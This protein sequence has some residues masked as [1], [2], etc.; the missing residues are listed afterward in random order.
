MEGMRMSVL[1]R[2]LDCIPDFWNHNF[3]CIVSPPLIFEGAC[4][5]LILEGVNTRLLSAKI[6]LLLIANN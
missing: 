6:F 5:P 2:F 3:G 4:P 1:S